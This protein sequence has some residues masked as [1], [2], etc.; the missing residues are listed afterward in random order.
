MVRTIHIALL[1]ILL[2][3]SAWAQQDVLAEALRKYQA[4]ALNLSLIHI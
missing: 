4:G 3:P 1:S 2:M